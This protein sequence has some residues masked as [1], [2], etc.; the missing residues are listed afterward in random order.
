M[1]IFDEIHIFFSNPLTKSAFFQRSFL[2]K[3]GVF[4]A[5]LW[6][7]SLFSATLSQ[8]LWDLFKKSAFYI[9]FLDKICILSDFLTK[10]TFYSR[11]FNKI[12]I[13]RTIFT[14]NWHF[15]HDLYIKSAIFWWNLRFICIFLAKSAFSLQ[16]SLFNDF[17]TK[18]EFLHDLFT[19]T[20][21]S[22]CY[23]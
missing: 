3:I 11:S 13:L 19:K 12:G 23:L 7:N 18:F 9:R 10:S 1:G 5:I 16:S 2:T 21:F 8:N 17:A 4:P 14:Q 22:H 20:T 6:H 15:I